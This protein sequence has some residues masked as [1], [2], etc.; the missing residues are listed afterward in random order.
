MGHEDYDGIRTQAKTVTGMALWGRGRTLARAPGGPQMLPSLRVTSNMLTTLGLRPALGRD[1]LPGEDVL[2]G[3]HVAM[4]SWETWQKEWNGDSSLVGKSVELDNVP[5]TVIGILPRG[6][7][8]DRSAPIAA[9]WSPALQDSSDLVQRHNRSY[10][11]LARLKPGATIQQATAEVSGLLSKLAIDSRGPVR[12]KGVAA[13]VEE[14]QIDQTRTVRASLWILFGAVGLLLLIACVNVATLMLGEAARRESEI[15]ARVA[16]GAGPERIARQLLTE[17]ITLS[18]LGAIIGCAIAAVSVQ[19]LV[20]MAPAGIPGIDSVHLDLRAVA[21]AVAVAAVTGILFGLAPALVLLRRGQQK[22]VRVGAGQ[23]ARGGR[24]VQH[25][26]I[27]VE[28]ALSLVL[29]AGCTLLGRSLERLTATDPGFDVRGLT[30]IQFDF[31][32]ELWRDQPRQARYV[33]AA[34][35]ELTALPGATAISAG[36]GVPFTGSNS[37]SPVKSDAREYGPDESGGNAQQRAILPG[38]LRAMGTPVL[39]GRTFNDGDRDG[40]ELVI[41]VSEAEARRDF[42]GVAPVGRR[43]YWQGQWRTVVG[44]VGDV[45]YA[46]LSRNNEPMVYVPFDQYASGN[47]EFVVRSASGAPSL[48]RAIR[49]RLKK[50]DAGVSVASIDRMSD[51]IGKSY[52]EERYR[53]L[54]A[55]LFGAIAS[56]LAIVGIF[57]VVSRGV[58]RRTREA[59]IR[60]ALGASASVLTRAMMGETLLGVGLGLMIGIPAAIA[61]SRLMKP[62]LFGVSP[63]DPVALGAAILLLGGAAMLA[64]YRPAQR[65]ARVDPV[66]AL[67]AE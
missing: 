34:M 10:A 53:T 51:L 37:S 2:N 24:A 52:G 35:R 13:R 49:D 45:K 25:T 48:Q 61:A 38:Y 43:L 54:L 9:V 44:V 39:A 42:A 21:F 1:F 15:A 57:G 58:A 5:Y 47:F 17:S 14:W 30:A 12:G 56:I 18:L 11:A 59:G 40:S 67:R 31:D 26:L 41:I 19:V 28:V 27:A 66:I 63:N 23:T 46:Q 33:S 64:T 36:S 4:L 29:L 6:L 7:R 3:P 62:F 50:I 8:M 60:A 16:L 22:A 32:R 20:A 55:S 65:A